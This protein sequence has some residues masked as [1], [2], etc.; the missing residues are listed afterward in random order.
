MKEKHVLKKITDIT[1]T[2]VK[3]EIN[4]KEVFETTACGIKEDLDS[5]GL[6]A[7]KFNL[8]SSM[9]DSWI[10]IILGDFE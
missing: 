2:V 9:I 4:G 3:K 10:K 7:D 1:L 6:T 8:L 5:I